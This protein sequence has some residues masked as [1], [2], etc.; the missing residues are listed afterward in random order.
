MKNFTSRMIINVIAIP[1]IILMIRYGQWPLVIF[2]TLV[3][4]LG[5]YEFYRLLRLKGIEPVTIMGIAAG[6]IWNL[7]VYFFPDL[8]GPV[9]MFCIATLALTVLFLPVE[10]ATLRISTTFWGLIYI[11]VLFSTVVLLR[12]SQPEYHQ[13]GRLVLLLFVTVWICDSLAFVFGKWLGR[14][15]MA[16]HISPHKTVAGCIAGLIG[17]VLTVWL[18]RWLDWAPAMLD[19]KELTIFGLLVG[20]FGQAGDFVESVFKRDAHVKDSGTLLM[21]HGGVLDRFDAFFIIAP[22]IYAYIRLLMALS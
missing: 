8:I 16:A 7:T 12:Q 15:K 3:S 18:F 20:V 22:V 21:G 17:A 19:W 5:Q 1:L 9:L 4:F 6:L 11:P 2:V 10:G 13:G 14:R